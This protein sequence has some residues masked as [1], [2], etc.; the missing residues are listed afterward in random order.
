LYLFPALLTLNPRKNNYNDQEKV[1]YALE[2]GQT[3]AALQ[4]MK[5]MTSEFGISP[6]SLNYGASRIISAWDSNTAVK[7]C[8]NLNFEKVV[9]ENIID[10]N[11]EVI[12]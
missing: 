1:K 12:I 7:A 3:V 2:T 5:K 6:E 10:A 9:A 11:I 4:I 8:R